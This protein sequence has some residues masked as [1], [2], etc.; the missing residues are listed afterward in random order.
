MSIVGI[1]SLTSANVFKEGSASTISF[2]GNAHESR[3]DLRFKS[4]TLPS[5]QVMPSHLQTE[6]VSESQLVWEIHS[7]PLHE[8]YIS[9][10]ASSCVY[11]VLSP[12]QL[13]LPKYWALLLLWSH[14]KHGSVDVDLPIELYV[15]GA[16]SR[17]SQ[18]E[19]GKPFLA[20]SQIS[21]MLVMWFCCKYTLLAIELV[22][23]DKILIRKRKLDNSALLWH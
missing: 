18:P 3:L 2:S 10:M 7:A 23:K 17:S 20:T 1:R 21:W 6:I 19:I 22:T 9:L 14:I 4:V 16:H 12:L 13:I 11:D 15:P 5:E 8:E